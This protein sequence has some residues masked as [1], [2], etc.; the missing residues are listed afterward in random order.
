VVL[1][2]RFFRAGNLLSDAPFN[3]RRLA[4]GWRE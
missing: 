4:T 1:A 2:G 3:W